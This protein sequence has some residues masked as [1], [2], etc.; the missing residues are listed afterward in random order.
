MVIISKSALTKYGIANAQAVEALAA[1]Y[2]IVKLADWANFNQLRADIPSADYIGNDRYI[3]NI[4]GNHYRL[5]ALIF[6]DIRT[7]FI[8]GIYTH[9][10][11]TKLIPRLP[12][13]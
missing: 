9:A 7:V 4:K 10:E 3:F 8:H 2:Q 6:F 13:L 1:W 12:T 11:Y 5:L